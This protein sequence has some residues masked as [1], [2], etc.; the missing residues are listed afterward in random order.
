MVRTSLLLG[1][2]LAESMLA[3]ASL[4]AQQP[5]G[6]QTRRPVQTRPAAAAPATRP[7]PPEIAPGKPRTAE[8][9]TQVQ[10]EVYELKLKNATLTE[11]DT[12]KLAQGTRADVLARLGEMGEARLVH[13]IDIPMLLDSRLDASVKLGSHVPIIRH[14]AVTTKGTVTP[15]VDYQDMG[16]WVELR[17][18]WIETPDGPRAEA[19][20]TLEWSGAGT[21]TI[22]IAKD[23]KLPV[24]T[25][26]KFKQMIQVASG[27]PLVFLARQPSIV[28]D[29]AE[30]VTVGLIRLTLTQFKP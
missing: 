26:F 29:D 1:L 7:A 10:A 22:E 23:V 5:T 12:G 8:Q 17:G 25:Q 2:L 6:S 21:S 15:S 4:Y 28:R 13:L 14:V 16:V 9:R 20:L 19:V 30:G 11:I 27:Q 3:P 18:A 24:F